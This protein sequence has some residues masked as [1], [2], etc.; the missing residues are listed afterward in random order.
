VQSVTAYPVDPAANLRRSA[1]IGAVLG[2]LS[3]V[4]LAVIG[5]PL[6]GV[7]ACLGLAIGAVNNLMLQRSVLQ[8]ASAGVGKGRFR[9]G[10]VARLGGITILSVA[11]ALLVRPDGIGIFAGLAVFQVLM[12]VGAALPVLRSMRPSA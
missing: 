11:L 4:G 10:V 6:A 9:G 12:L 1:V 5:H 2:V 3:I 8:Y 7:F